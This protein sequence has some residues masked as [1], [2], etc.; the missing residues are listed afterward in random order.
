M[1]KS[2]TARDVDEIQSVVA[3]YLKTLAFRK[4]GRTFNRE[5]EDGIV[6]VVNLQMGPYPIGKYVIPGLRENLYGKFAV[7]LGIRLPCISA[8]EG[9]PSGKKIYREYDCHIRSRLSREVDGRAEEWWSIEGDFGRIGSEIAGLL[10]KSGIPFFDQFSSYH[11]V[12][13]F[14]DRRGVFPFRTDARSALDAALVCRHC[15]QVQ[16]YEALLQEAKRRA[17]DH[18]GFREYVSGIEKKFEERG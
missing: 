16:R 1:P 13:V 14:Y 10:E 8:A 7:N 11:D 17:P 9:A 5:R 18:K 15:G 4:S 3:A 2:D 12:I 6:H